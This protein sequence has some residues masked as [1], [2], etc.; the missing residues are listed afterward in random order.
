MTISFEPLQV[1]SLKDICVSRLEQLILSGELKIGERL[2]AE[3]DFAAKLGVSRPVLHEALVDLATKG[4]VTILPRRG[5]VINDYRKAGSCAILSSLLAYHQ[6]NFDPEFIRSMFAMRMLLETES[7]RLAAVE[8]SEDERIQMQAILRAEE[9]IDRQNLTA[10]VDLDFEFHLLISIASRNMVYPLIINSFKN[11]YTHFTR[12]FFLKGLTNGVLDKV[13][14]YHRFL[15]EAIL[16]R[17]QAEAEQWMMELLAH[18]EKYL[19]G[20]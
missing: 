16:N 15:V 17:N 9:T 10:L 4:L 14:E 3:R 12:E 8:A 11:V 2:P 20:E 19:K 6:G 7:A 1:Q 5:V 13:Y 18:G